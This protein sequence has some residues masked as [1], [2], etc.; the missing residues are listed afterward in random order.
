V[1][2]MQN[3]ARSRIFAKIC[4]FYMTQGS[5]L[6]SAQEHFFTIF[7]NFRILKIRKFGIL[8]FFFLKKFLMKKPPW[9]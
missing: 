7:W 5:S 8:I 9:T 1:G 2:K 4:D 3:L 6:I